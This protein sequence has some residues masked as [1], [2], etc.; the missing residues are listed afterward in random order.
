MSPCCQGGEGRVDDFLE[1][2]AAVRS[3][4]RVKLQHH[5]QRQEQVPPEFSSV[6]ERAEEAES[7][8]GTYAADVKRALGSGHAS[9]DVIACSD[10]VLPGQDIWTKATVGEALDGVGESILSAFQADKLRLC[11]CVGARRI[12]L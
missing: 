2:G 1:Q 3:G 8:H 9:R 11:C 10:A 6:E 7:D 5:Q 4:D 12:Q